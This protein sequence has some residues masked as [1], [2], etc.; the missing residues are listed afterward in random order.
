MKIKTYRKLGKFSEWLRRKAD[1]V[2]DYR[3][4]KYHQNKPPNQR[5]N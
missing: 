2:D 4:R 1:Q 5:H 3:V